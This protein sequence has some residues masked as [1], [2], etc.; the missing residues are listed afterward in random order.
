MN[1]GFCCKSE[2]LCQAFAIMPNEPRAASH[3]QSSPVRPRP[4]ASGKRKLL[5]H[6]KLRV[7]RM[8][9]VGIAAPNGHRLLHRRVQHN[10]FWHD[11]YAVMSALGPFCQLL[12]AFVM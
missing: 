6:I 4:I 5:R 12:R 2:G 7:L 1:Y 11:L 8:R 9:C 3:T 10:G